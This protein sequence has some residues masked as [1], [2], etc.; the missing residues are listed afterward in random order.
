MPITK[1]STLL[2]VAWF[3]VFMI[4]KKLLTSSEDAPSVDEST[5]HCQ[6]SNVGRPAEF[7]QRV[8]NLIID[9]PSMSIRP[10]AKQ[11]QMAEI[12]IRSVI[13]E[14][15]W[16]HY[17]GTNRVQIMSDKTCKKLCYPVAALA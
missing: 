2:N 7:I 11:I 4:M 17:H 3:F 5:N 16:N 15:L 13:N 12:T 1:I 14:N 10:N 8:Q 6:W 9:D